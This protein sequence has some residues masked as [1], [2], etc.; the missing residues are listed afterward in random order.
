MVALITAL[1]PVALQLFDTIQRAIAAAKQ[2]GEL[3][4]DQEAAFQK[5]L[6]EVWSKDYAQPR[7]QV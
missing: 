3:T 6:N 4:P 7:S 1:I 2:S 5:R